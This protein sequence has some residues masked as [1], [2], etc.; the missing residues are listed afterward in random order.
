MSH[1]QVWWGNAHIA[2]ATSLYNASAHVI[3]SSRLLS[4][5]YSFPARLEGIC[6]RLYLVTGCGCVYHVLH[7][8]SLPSLALAVFWLGASNISSPIILLKKII[9]PESRL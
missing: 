3:Y 4:L 1:L 7:M 8:I 2:G 6:A 5:S 9:V